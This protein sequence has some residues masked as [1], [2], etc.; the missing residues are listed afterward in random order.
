MGA[1]ASIEAEKQ[2][3][4]EE[5]S[6][7]D[8][9]IG[10]Y[11]YIVELGG[12]LPPLPDSLK[13]EANRVQGC[14]SRVWFHATEGEDGVIRFAADSDAVI[15]KGLISLLLRVYSGRTAEDIIATTPAFF[16]TIEL[17]SHLTGSRANGLH[18]MVRR[19]HAIARA[20]LERRAEGAVP[21]AL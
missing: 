10:R 11:E 18:A 15:V 13:T 8:D 9:W 3:I 21:S 12:K 1:T 2:Q 17:G 6:I 19:I 20:S 7:F 4:V 16:E 5:F 14:Q